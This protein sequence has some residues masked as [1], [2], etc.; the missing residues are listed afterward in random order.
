MRFIIGFFLIILGGVLVSTTEIALFFVPLFV[1]IFLFASITTEDSFCD[2]ITIDGANVLFRRRHY[3]LFLPAHIVYQILT[4]GKGALLIP[5]KEEYFKADLVDSKAENAKPIDR[6]TYHALRMEQRQLYATQTPSWEFM[7][8]TYDHRNI[9][10]KRK[11]NR[12]IAV[13]VLAGLML[14]N[15]TEPDIWPAVL[16]FDACFLPAIL[17]WIPEYKD[18]KALQQAYDRAISAAPQEK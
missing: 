15:V 9:G 7:D 4:L 8:A 5:W 1:G 16:A 11:R 6:K 18:A 12:L 10:F 17:L 14:V 13:S 2:Y 3:I